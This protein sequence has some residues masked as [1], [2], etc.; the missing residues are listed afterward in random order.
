MRH[1]KYKAVMKYLPV[2]TGVLLLS[3]CQ[4]VLLDPK[5][6]IAIKKN[7][8]SALCRNK[9]SRCDIW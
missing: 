9:Q 6:Q 7:R 4:A 3:G 8:G 2:I 5:G 1:H